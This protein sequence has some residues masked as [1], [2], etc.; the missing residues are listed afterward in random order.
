MRSRPLGPWH[1]SP[2]VPMRIL[3]LGKR[4]Y[5]NKDAL[6][7]RYGRIY[8]VPLNWARVGHDVT[9]LL[10][11]YRSLGSRE[12][13][14]DGLRVVSIPPLALLRTFL[15]KPARKTDLVVASGDCFLGLLASRIARRSG[16]AFAFDVYDDYRTFGGY[17]LFLGWDAFGRL[18]KTANHTFYA[19]RAL[20]QHHPSGH[21]WSALP[22]AIDETL[23]RPLC[24]V[25]ARKSLGLSMESEWIGYLGS[26]EP[27]RGIPDLVAAVERLRERRPRVKLLLCGRRNAAVQLDKDFIE[28]RGEIPNRQ[29]P[30]YLAAC[31][32]VA[33][34]YRRGPF[35][36]MASSV[37]IA[38]YL[39]SA[40][41]LAAT[42]SPN[43]VANFPKQARELGDRL[44][45]PGSIESLAGVIEK[46]LT[47]PIL[48]S[49]AAGQTWQAVAAD[50]LAAISSAI[51][52]ASKRSS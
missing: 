51:H 19:S 9:L 46:Q 41:P 1:L 21:S 35:I 14:D 20:G 39:A 26:M 12:Q 50:G 10:A 17:R 32:V 48:A 29:V 15:L 30:G 52:A 27:E 36:D 24:K 22:N 47:A 25:D 28:Y 37:K 23:F 42:S 5:T 16:A 43:F 44:A 11:D 2:A 40:R 6:L 18:V 8:Q 45:T 3:V 33:L 13:S 31:D 49:I 38:E 7:E 4:Y 34:P